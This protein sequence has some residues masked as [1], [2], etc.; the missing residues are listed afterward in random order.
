MKYLLDA[1]AVLAWLQEESGHLRVDALIRKARNKEVNLILG[2]V[3][4]GEVFYTYAKTRGIEEAKR[5]EQLLRLLP[6]NIVAP[7]EEKLVMSAAHL[8]AL[9]P[10]SYA[11]AFAAALTEK[12]KAI[13]VTG[14]TDFKKVEKRIKIEWLR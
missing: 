3:N 8:K 5:A 1:W 14:D 13:L 9:Y 2:I 6:I 11:D 4:F 7:V 10:V 12:E